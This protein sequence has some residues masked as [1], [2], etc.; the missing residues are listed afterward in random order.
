MAVLL[1]HRAVAVLTHGLEYRAAG[2]SRTALPFFVA[3]YNAFDASVGLSGG[4]LARYVSGHP[5]SRDEVGRT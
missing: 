2:V 3:F 5:A 1:V 4:L